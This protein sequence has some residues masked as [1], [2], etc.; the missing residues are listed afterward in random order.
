MNRNSRMPV[1]NKWT[2]LH[3]TALNGD[4]DLIKQLLV[5]GADIGAKLIDGSRA[6]LIAA[7]VGH[8]KVV[9][10]LLAVGAEVDGR[11]WTGKT[12]LH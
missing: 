2:L 3:F 12:A 11:T 5:E 9:R 7:T 10:Q 1:L 6:L 4:S 8:V